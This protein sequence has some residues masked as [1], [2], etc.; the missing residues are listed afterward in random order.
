MKNKVII[1]ILLVIILVTGS[2]IFIFQKTQK[3]DELIPP[4][5]FVKI[6]ENEYA[7]LENT[8]KYELSY[9]ENGFEPSESVVDLG[10][11]KELAVY[12]LKNSTNKPMKLKFISTPTNVELNDPPVTLDAGK[13][14]VYNFSSK[15]VYIIGNLDNPDHQLTITIQ[16]Q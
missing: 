2:A 11:D 14:T 13:S 15:G 8:P 4:K 1:A 7:Y 9:T 3:S 12:T 16:K 5:G 10:N 6:S